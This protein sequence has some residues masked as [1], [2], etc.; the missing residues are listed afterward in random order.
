MTVKLE[1]DVVEVPRTPEERR[2]VA[3]KRI[4]AKNDFKTHLIVY[5]AVNTLL[6]VLWAL[7]NAGEPYPQGAFWPII[8]IV[9]WGVAVVINAYAVYRKDVYTEDRIQREMD[10]MSR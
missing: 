8:P 9:G 10:K 7:N 5:L 6:V 2:Q 3:I 1:E 4:K